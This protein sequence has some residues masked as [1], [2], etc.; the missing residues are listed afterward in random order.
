MAVLILVLCGAVE[1]SVLT[2]TNNAGYDIHELYITASGTGNWGNDLL[3]EYYLQNGGEYEI[4][5]PNYDQ[6]DIKVVDAG[7]RWTDWRNI[8][9]V[10]VR[11]FVDPN[12]Q[13]RWEWD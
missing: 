4:T 6:F 2:I 1:A 11:F 5:I 12:K 13:A 9:G 7:G 3:G 10:V 8:P